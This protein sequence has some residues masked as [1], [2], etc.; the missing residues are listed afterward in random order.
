LEARR[1]EGLDARLV[2]K[3]FVSVRVGLWLIKAHSS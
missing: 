3:L 1:L 2:Q